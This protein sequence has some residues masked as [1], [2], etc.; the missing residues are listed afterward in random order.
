MT[1]TGNV[2]TFALP[3]LTSYWQSLKLRAGCK[4]LSGVTQHT[5]ECVSISNVD[6][7]QTW[8]SDIPTT[9]ETIVA[10]TEAERTIKNGKVDGAAE[11]LAESIAES[12]EGLATIA[13]TQA[14][15]SFKQ[16]EKAELVLKEQSIISIK[17]AEAIAAIRAVCHGRHHGTPHAKAAQHVSGVQSRDAGGGGLRHHPAAAEHRAH[18]GRS[19]NEDDHRAGLTDQAHSDVSTS[20]HF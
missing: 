14:E 20:S 9:K 1:A 4:V 7:P 13:R 10:T 12:F 16:G 3:L 18:P 19:G 15:E 11:G 17:A 5:I 8:T 6:V 2:R